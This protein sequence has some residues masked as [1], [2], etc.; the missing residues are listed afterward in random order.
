MSP[1]KSILKYKSAFQDLSF[2][3]DCFVEQIHPSTKSK[4]K[5]VI[6]ATK[7]FD[8]LS[9]LDSISHRIDSNSVVLVLSNGVLRVAEDIQSRFQDEGRRKSDMPLILLGLTTHGSIRQQ[10][11]QPAS[12]SLTHTGLGSTMIGLTKFTSYTNQVD[13]FREILEKAWTNSLLFSFTSN[14]ETLYLALTKKLVTNSC[15]NPL[16]AI[17]ECLN[18]D[19]VAPE[20]I[21]IMSNVCH[22]AIDL[23]PELVGIGHD[24]LVFDAIQVATSTRANRNSMLVDIQSNQN[25]QT[26]IDYLNGYIVKRALDLNKKAIVNEMLTRLIKMKCKLKENI[27]IL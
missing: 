16:A 1:I 4:I 6:I 25:N 21:E 18:G 19:L 10:S 9:A 14:P 17:L 2:Q 5:H 12:L 11:G 24:R 3:G 8:C 22:E 20:L 13:Q 23:F 26:E 27:K 15:L 7:A